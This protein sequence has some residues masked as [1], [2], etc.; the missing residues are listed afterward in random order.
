MET[1]GGGMECREQGR[2]CCNGECVAVSSY[3]SDPKHCG[4]CIVECEKDEKC[5]KGVC[6]G[7]SRGGYS[8]VVVHKVTSSNLGLERSVTMK[9]VVRELDVP[10]EE[11]NTFAGK[12]SYDGWARRYNPSCDNQQRTKYETIPLTGQAKGSGNAD[13][14]GNGQIA[15]VF[16]ITPLNPPENLPEGVLPAL[17]N[18][19]LTRGSGQ[20]RRTFKMQSDRCRGTLTHVTEWSAKRIR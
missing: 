11:G 6:V 13:D 18:L 1:R 10:D 2:E 16:T 7:S 17:G 5:V 20:D 3:Q 4:K 14:M 15:L 12:G 8:L 9:A 19:V